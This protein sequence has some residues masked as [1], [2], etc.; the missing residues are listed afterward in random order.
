MIKLFGGDQTQNFTSVYLVE[1][2]NLF[3]EQEGNRA[4]LNHPNFLKKIEKE[5][6]EE[7]AEENIYFRL[8]IKELETGSTRTKVYELNYEQSLQILMSE[9]KFVRKAVIEVL[10]RQQSEIESKNA[11]KELTRLEIL[12]MAIESEKRAI[13][14]ESKVAILMHVN[15]NYTITEIA[16]EIGLSSAKKLND[17]LCDKKIQFKQNGTYVPYSQY[18]TQ[19]YFDIN[20]EVLDNGHVIYHRRVTQIGRDFILNLFK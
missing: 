13:E 4:V 14:A 18:S 10:K 12:T 19:G 16:K 15:K 3:R 6:K 9:S 2:I 7:I 17:I 8:I 20:Q 11:P 1:Q 5:F